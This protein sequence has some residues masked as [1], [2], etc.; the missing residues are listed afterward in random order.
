[1]ETLDGMVTDI[2]FQNEENG[3]AI[4]RFHVDQKGDYSAL[5][6]LAGLRVGEMVRLFG[7]FEQDKRWG[8]QFRVSSFEYRTEAGVREI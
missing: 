4:V 1:M 7:N 2:R 3:F 5:G 6:T 8:E